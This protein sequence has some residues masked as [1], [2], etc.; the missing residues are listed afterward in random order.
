MLSNKDIKLI[1]DYIRGNLNDDQKRDVENRLKE[2]ES[3]KK[4]FDNLVVTQKAIKNYLKTEKLID[5]TVSL[6]RKN[7]KNKNMPFESKKPFLN[8]SKLNNRYYRTGLLAACIFIFVFLIQDTFKDNSLRMS[9][10]SIDHT[11]EVRE[12]Y[13][14]FLDEEP[15]FEHLLT[16]VWQQRKKKKEEKYW[17][18]LHAQG[19]IGAEQLGKELAKIANTIPKTS[20]NDKYEIGFF[21]NINTFLDGASEDE[22]RVFHNIKNNDIYWDTDA[23][24]GRGGLRENYQIGYS[25]DS[26]GNITLSF[27]ERTGGE[28]RTIHQI[29]ANIYD[30]EG[31]WE[32]L[33]PDFERLI[34]E[35]YNESLEP[36]S[37][38][39]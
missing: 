36:T 7:T 10:S 32:N 26:D 1:E 4:T 33:G 5:N 24:N 11:L 12:E 13:K 34:R 29:K 21:Y 19:K 25:R 2:D 38:A 37:S 16:P 22:K 23:N 30:Q 18:D 28:T 9:E 35:S 31:A 17:Q 20:L 14:D 6:I 39:D 8:F 15:S 27:E 3:F